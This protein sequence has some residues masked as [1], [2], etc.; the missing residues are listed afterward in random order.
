MPT[1]TAQTNPYAP[2]VER[3][4]FRMRMQ[5]LLRKRQDPNYV[6][7]A[8]EQMG[9]DPSIVDS[10]LSSVIQG[11]NP[12]DVGNQSAGG[13]ISSANALELGDSKAASAMLDSLQNTLNEN[14][15]ILGPV[16]GSVRGLN[17]YDTTAQSFQAQVNATKQIVG[18]YLEGGVLRLEDEK[19]YEKI[20]PKLSDT[21]EVAQNKI[22]EVR[23]LIDNKYASQI[24]TLGGAGYNVSGLAQQEQGGQQT[25]GTIQHPEGKTLDVQKAQVWLQQNPNDPRAEQVK[26]ILDRQGANNQNQLTTN[27]NNQNQTPGAVD[28]TG[29][30]QPQKGWFQDILDSANRRADAVGAIEGSNQSTGSKALQIFGQGTGLGADIIGTV[31]GHTLSAVTPDSIEKPVSE[32]VGSALTNI[33]TSSPAQEVASNWE[34]FKKSHPELAGNIEAAGNAANLGASLYGA[35]ALT[36]AVGKALPSAANAVGKTAELTGKAV[37]GTGKFATSQVTG[38]TRQGITNIVDN[39]QSFTKEA[40]ASAD[41]MSLGNKVKEAIDGRIAQLA[42]TGKAYQGIRSGGSVVVPTA[43][44]NATLAKYGITVGENGKIVATSET[45]P[46]SGADKSAIEGFLSQYG[47][48]QL[49]GNGFL[50]ARQALSEMARFDASSGKTGYAEKIAKDLRKTFDS[51]GKIQLKGL[52]ETDA[53]YAPEVK[54]LNQ[55]KKDYFNTDGSLKDGALSK[56]ANLGGKGKDLVLKRLEEVVPTIRQ[57]INVVKTI[58]ELQTADFKVGAYI[59]G[60]L[61]GGA[62][63]GGNPVTALIGAMV[64]NPAVSVPIIRTYGVVKGI[65]T[66]GII[67]KLQKGASLAK[68]ELKILDDAIIT[69]SGKAESGLKSYV[70]GIRPGMNIQDVS[71]GKPGYTGR[72]GNL[73]PDDVKALEDYID[74]VRLNKKDVLSSSGTLGAE[75]IFQKLGINMDTSIQRLA[76]KAEDILKGKIDASSLYKT[77]REFKNAIKNKPTN[78]RRR[79]LQR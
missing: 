28:Q 66:D 78:S 14:K 40:M 75:H 76:N 43:D 20:L 62:I 54:Q 70:K 69:A 42:E 33:L 74:A 13:T 4:K 38:I 67:G 73:H 17:P 50:N 31:I 1:T 46:L 5:E 2:N 29:Q 11:T 59:K 25:Q 30:E 7:Y 26:A 47:S 16:E 61:V 53:K 27:N 45:V 34:D 65:V 77:G 57:D 3:S 24:Q 21:P 44:V 58:E 35:K 48:H 64:S 15:G 51:H 8:F 32:A 72:G 68:S 79:R 18:K 55:L 6:K 10:E 36:N 49:T 23:K 71:G 37:G 41:R 60:G 63:G 39:P 22:N 12:P 19:K 52:A 9:Y 56:I